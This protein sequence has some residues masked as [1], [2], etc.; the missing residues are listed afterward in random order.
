MFYLITL[1]ENMFE[2][3]ESLDRR[4]DRYRGRAT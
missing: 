3:H 2:P 4:A 1:W